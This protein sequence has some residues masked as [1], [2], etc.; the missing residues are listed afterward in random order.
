MKV[1]IFEGCTVVKN[2]R[3][4]AGVLTVEEQVNEFLEANP[5][6]EIKHVNQSSTEGGASEN[7]SNITTISIWY[8]EAEAIG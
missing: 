8:E 5:S 1:A 2:H 7:Y 3:Q 4:K 6:I